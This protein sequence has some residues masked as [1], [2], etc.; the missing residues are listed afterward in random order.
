MNIIF[1]CDENYASYLAV[2]ILS[3]LEKNKNTKIIF[4]ILDLKI[5]EE[6]KK[7]ITYFV[8][9][10]KCKIIFFQI[11]ENKFNKL[12][13]M[14]QHVPKATFARLF[15]HEYLPTDLKKVLY[16]DC[17]III[18]QNLKELYETDLGEN[19]L[20][21]IMDPFIENNQYKKTIDL[22]ANNLYFNAGVLLINLKK[23]RQKNF[24]DFFHFFT[25]KFPN[26]QYQ[27]QDILN[28]LFQN[29]VQFLDMRYNFQSFS[30]I[31]FRKK[32]LKNISYPCTMPIAIFHDTGTQKAWHAKNFNSSAIYFEKYF[33]ILPNKPQTWLNK[34]EKIPFFIKIK[35][36][37]KYL[38]RKF[39]YK[40]Y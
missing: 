40:I 23:W 18:N 38:Q 15:L 22:K 39:L 26:A 35:R 16:L 21:V 19:T 24:N 33:Q 32:I 20:G 30:R 29:E 25:K 31:F 28:A 17:D 10:R 13:T 9:D 34:R 37:C 3:I 5:S 2:T 6:S 27:D 1:S 11:N 14:V 7:Y 4:Y 36:I 12:N 8:E